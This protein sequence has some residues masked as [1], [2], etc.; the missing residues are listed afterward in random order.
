MN[1]KKTLTYIPVLLL[2]AL[3]FVSL[4]LGSCQNGRVPETLSEKKET[5]SDSVI[6]EGAKIEFDTLSFD[7]GRIYEGEVVAWN[8][9]YT[10]RGDRDLVLT[11]VKA[12]CGCTS[13]EYSNQPL[14]PGKKGS[15]RIAFDSGGR[16]GR[17]YET[18][19]VSSNTDPG[20]TELIITAI[21]EKK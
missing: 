13:P 16:T 10:N 1:R 17:Q 11:E 6:Y 21:V 2:T 9:G 5:L 14:A 3:L 20:I 8:F 12:T 15:V 7:F 18:V 4:C 19:S